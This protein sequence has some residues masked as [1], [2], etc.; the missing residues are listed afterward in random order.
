VNAGREWFIGWRKFFR[1]GPIF[2]YDK[3]RD[4]I[5]RG[6]CAD[7]VGVIW[8]ADIK[9]FEGHHDNDNRKEGR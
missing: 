7:P 4:W 8:I 2:V 1:L 5:I 9:H 6:E 3:R